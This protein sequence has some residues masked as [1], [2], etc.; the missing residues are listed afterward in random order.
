MSQPT[1]TKRIEQVI[2]TYIDACNHGDTN[3]ICSCFGSEA[4]HYFPHRSKWVGATTV[5][6][7]FAEMVR[8]RGVYWTVDQLLVDIDRC[9]AALEWTMFNRKDGRILRGVDWFV[10][11][12]QSLCISEIRA[13][14]AAPP[15]P[16]IV[17]QE[18]QDF[19][20]TAKG[21]PTT[22]P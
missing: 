10:F 3:A 12:P 18:L 9:A 11:E 19:D 8:E 4:V 1:H 17:H 5:G 22:P 2:K 14:S 13:Y 6:T 21:Y 15:H 20:Y 7:N 16:D